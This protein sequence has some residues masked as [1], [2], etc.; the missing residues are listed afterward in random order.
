MRDYR[1]SGAVKF[2]TPGQLLPI[3]R[4]KTP[5]ASSGDKPREWTPISDAEYDSLS[6]REKIR[7]QRILAHE[8]YCKAGPMW[9]TPQGGTTLR[10]PVAGHVAERD[11]PDIWRHWRSIGQRHDAEAKRLQERL[12]AARSNT[13]Q[14]RGG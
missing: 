6:L 12:L 10:R 13:Q 2:P 5:L 1:H 4:A 14:A 8:A 3:V 9:K 7:H 11:M